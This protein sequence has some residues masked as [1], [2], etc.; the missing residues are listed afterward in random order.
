[1]TDFPTHPDPSQWDDYV[2]FEST[3]GN[4]PLFVNVGARYE[5]TEL[6]SFG[7]QRQL[8]DL[9]PTGGNPPTDPTILKC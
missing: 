6:S 7:Q 4:M 5:Y 2:D 3:I 9:T 1:M 8:V